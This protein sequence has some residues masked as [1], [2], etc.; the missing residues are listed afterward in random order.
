M[1][2]QELKDLS[3]REFISALWGEN[4]LA[5]IDAQD[6]VTMSMK[7]FLTHCTACGGNWGAMLLTGIKELFPDVYAIIPDDMG[8]FAWACLCNTITLLGVNS[9]EV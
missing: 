6:K 4:V 3:E 1:T 5:V 7:E 9:E 2:I 8:M